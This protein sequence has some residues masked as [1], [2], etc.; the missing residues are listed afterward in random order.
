LLNRTKSCIAGAYTA[1]IDISS[2]NEKIEGIRLKITENDGEALWK[3]RKGHLITYEY[4]SN[5]SFKSKGLRRINESS[6]IDL[7]TDNSK[8][9]EFV[10]KL[11]EVVYDKN[12][13][14]TTRDSILQHL[15]RL[16]SQEML[17]VLKENFDYRVFFEDPKLNT[18]SDHFKATIFKT[19]NK[20]GLVN[21]E[22]QDKSFYEYFCGMLDK[23]QKDG[24]ENF[25]ISTMKMMFML[26]K[27]IS[28]EAFEKNYDLLTNFIFKKALPQLEKSDEY[29]KISFDASQNNH[30]N[31]G[32]LL[33]RAKNEYE[34]TVDL[35]N[36]HSIDYIKLLF[37]EDT[38]GLIF[39]MKISVFEVNSADKETLIFREL[40]GDDIYQ[41]CT[42]K[43]NSIE[44]ESSEQKNIYGSTINNFLWINLKKINT[45]S[46]YYRIKIDHIPSYQCKCS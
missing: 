2:I 31:T 39:S 46:R 42:K 7:Y 33:R 43:Y 26:N 34:L 35:G 6:I 11:I 45:Q 24:I 18:Y 32:V 12:E 27:E 1:E 10:K 41:L 37:D 20:V 30:I 22:S 4:P 15:N 29:Y 40:I 16:A 19:I 36:K 25:D 9:K 14:E 5:L 38:F 21:P 44:D 17:D 13:N 23:V 8:L 28:K 3:F